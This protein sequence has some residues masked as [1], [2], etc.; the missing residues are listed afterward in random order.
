MLAVS[1]NKDL[2]ELI[3]KI[4]KRNEIIEPALYNS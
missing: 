1:S 3:K 4:V 2:S